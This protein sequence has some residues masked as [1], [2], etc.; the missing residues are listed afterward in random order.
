MSTSNKSIRIS[1]PKTH[2]GPSDDEENKE[3]I[4]ETSNN[5]VEKEPETLPVPSALP[6]P[7]PITELKSRKIKVKIDTFSILLTIFSI[8]YYISLLCGKFFQN[9]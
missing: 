5:V 1:I 2:Y 7:T 9:Y 3:I 6:P 4:E 8:V